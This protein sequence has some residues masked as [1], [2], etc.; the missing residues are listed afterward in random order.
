MNISGEDRVHLI[1]DKY[2]GDESADL[3]DDA[4]RLALGEPLAY[5]IG[6]IPFLGLHIRLDSH[7]LIPRPETEWW[8]E[9][10]IEHLKERF[11]DAPC[12]VLDLCAGSGAIGLA[13]LKHLP[14]AH[15]SFGELSAAHAELVM[16]NIEENGLD[17]SRADVR[18]GD[19]FAPFQNQHFHIIAT[20][21]PY[22]PST[23]ALDRSV[24][25]YEPE[26]ALYAGTDGLELIRRLA[27]E[28]PRHISK[29]G[30]L[31]MEC[32]IENIDEAARLLA[33]TGA[34]TDI[35]T[36]LYGRKRL[37]LAYY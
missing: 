30:E 10:L 35:R 34:R 28:A 16:R 29:N 31:W 26:D 11:G 20:N 6:W 13:V 4:R 24:L 7:P 36:D 12:R 2:H 18:G 37:V 23:R 3:T 17:T 21:P 9:L 33:Q 8:T 14:N 25:D 27:T 32:D 15:V 5:V 19:L 22:I 1:R